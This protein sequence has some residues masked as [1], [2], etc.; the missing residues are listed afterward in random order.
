MAET[1]ARLARERND[2]ARTGVVTSKK[3]T[4]LPARS[5]RRSRRSF[6]AKRD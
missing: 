2:G 4:R 5:T 3:Y 6:D 1:Y